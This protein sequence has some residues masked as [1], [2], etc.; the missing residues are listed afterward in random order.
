[1]EII[2]KILG[3]FTTSKMYVEVVVEK[4][5]EKA[6][7]SGQTLKQYIHNDEN[8]SHISLVVYDCLPLAFKLGLRYEKFNQAFIKNFSI[9]RSKIFTEPLMSPE[10]E[11]QEPV[12]KKSVKK[13]A[14]TKK[15]TVD[16]QTYFFSPKK[17]KTP[18]VIS[19]KRVI[20]KS[21]AKVLKTVGNLMLVNT[22]D[23]KSLAKKLPDWKYAINKK[24]HKAI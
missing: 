1:M 7:T 13:T 18:S 12:V 19:A 16:N 24:T 23:V 15:V 21:G 22:E 4:I 5:T 3:Y 14:T 2:K 6:K 10:K 17:D 8:I 20:N 11:V 9:I